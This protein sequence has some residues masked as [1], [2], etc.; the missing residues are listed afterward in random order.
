M[1]CQRQNECACTA[2]PN[3]SVRHRLEVVF[4]NT[5]VGV[6]IFAKGD[7]RL[8]APRGAYDACAVV[9]VQK[10][11]CM[12]H[13]YD[14]IGVVSIAAIR[15]SRHATLSNRSARRCI[16]D[17]ARRL[18]G[19]SSSIRV[20]RRVTYVTCVLGRRH[21]ASLRAYPYRISGH[22]ALYR[23]V[24]S[25]RSNSRGLRRPSISE[26]CCTCKLTHR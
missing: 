16:L 23:K 26:P 13:E 25:V 9:E 5:G 12:Q 1:D 4:R 3:V 14:A 18:Q 17:D 2:G 10:S 8:E 22:P 20:S 11:T 24:H 21:R 19:T 6:M 7:V 15:V